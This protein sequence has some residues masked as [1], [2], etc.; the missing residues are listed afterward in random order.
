M[1]KMELNV[2]VLTKPIFYK[3]YV[4]DTYLW[5][6]KN[7]VDKLFEVLN[8]YNE[9]IK[10]K[11]EVNRTKSLDTEMVRENGEIKTQV[12]SKSKSCLFTA[13]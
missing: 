2:V 8:S 11:L 7:H 13:V 1:W 9:N 5:R 4:D 6:K 3:H 12:F 10:L